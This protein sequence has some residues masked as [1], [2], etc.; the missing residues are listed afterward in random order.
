MTVVASVAGASSSAGAGVASQLTG[1][2]LGA[3]SVF[4]AAALVLIL[5]YINV[6]RG[7]E[8]DVDRLRTLATTAA[9][10]LFVTFLAIAVFEAFVVL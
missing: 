5:A 9:V 7:S 2:G 4:I 8:R 3:G 6:L 10:P 1:T